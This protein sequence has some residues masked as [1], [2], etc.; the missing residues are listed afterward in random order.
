MASALSAISVV[1]TGINRWPS[2][3]FIQTPGS[4]ASGTVSDVSSDPFASMPDAPRR[5]DLSR[6]PDRGTDKTIGKTVPP[7]GA[8]VTF[9]MRDQ[10]R[11]SDDWRVYFSTGEAVIV[12]R[13]RD[14]LTSESVLRSEQVAYALGRIQRREF[15]S[16]LL[17][18]AL[19]FLGFL[20]ATRLPGVRSRL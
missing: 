17:Q 18:G 4:W 10:I 14:T 5:L 20:A 19:V 7:I 16:W 11:T 3:T 12:K 13:E 15:R 2:V 9:L 6:L 1:L 8:D